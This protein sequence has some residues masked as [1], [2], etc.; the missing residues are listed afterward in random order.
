MHSLLSRRG[1]RGLRGLRSLSRGLLKLLV[2]VVVM[3]VL[4]L[5]AFVGHFLAFTGPHFLYVYE[6]STSGTRSNSARAIIGH[7]KYI[8]EI[9]VDHV[10]TLELSVSEESEESEGSQQRLA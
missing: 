1:L 9:I 4:V 2:V 10:L 5:A 8:H 3:V 7:K 6:L